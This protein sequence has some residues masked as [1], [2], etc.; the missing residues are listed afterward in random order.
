MSFSLKP[1]I[2]ASKFISRLWQLNIPVVTW[3]NVNNFKSSPYLLQATV[4]L[5]EKEIM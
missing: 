1:D 3:Q 5:M 2:V 4:K